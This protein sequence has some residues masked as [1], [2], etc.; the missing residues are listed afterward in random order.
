MKEVE[1]AYEKLDTLQISGTVNTSTAHGIGIFNVSQKFSGCYAA[2]NK[3]RFQINARLQGN[4]DDLFGCTGKLVYSDQ[5]NH[6]QRMAGD[7]TAD[8]VQF[9]V[10][11]LGVMIYAPMEFVIVKDSAL[12]IVRA[13]PMGSIQVKQDA[14]TK[15][16]QTSYLTIVR[17]SQN[18]MFG[19]KTTLLVDPVTHLLRRQIDETAMPGGNVTTRVV[20]VE[21][22]KVNEKLDDEQF[23]WTPP[24]EWTDPNAKPAPAPAP[25]APPVPRA[26][27]DGAV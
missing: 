24:A 17:T 3:F 25:A 15:I 8:K 16:G 13:T 5:N 6:R 26:D 27:Q 23:R 19:T 4:A 11:T 21:S 22:T 10:M 20:D 7:A 14:D 9:P 12:R 18:G 1:A 2:P